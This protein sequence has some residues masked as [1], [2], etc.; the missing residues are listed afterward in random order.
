MKQATLC[1]L[2]KDNRILLGMKK[3]GFGQGK[4]NGFGGKVQEDE[5]IEHAARR[6]LHE[7][8]GVLANRMKKVAELAFHFPPEK[9]GWNQVVHIYM[10]EDWEGE[11]IESEEMT[12]EWFDISNI[13][14]SSMW[15]DDKHWLPQ[16]LAGKFVQGRFHF[17]EDGEE[18]ADMELNTKSF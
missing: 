18:I 11:P 8:S 13:P 6:E 2:V 5:S 4:Y 9:E 1:I 12:A 17:G 3:R 15:A 14:Y 10:V 16:V 7:E